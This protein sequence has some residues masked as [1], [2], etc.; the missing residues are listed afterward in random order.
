MQ[1]HIK[2]NYGA[3]IDIVAYL[4]TDRPIFGKKSHA[5]SNYLTLLLN[6]LLHA[7]LPFIWFTNIVG[8]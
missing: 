6:V 3:L 1:N 7:E 4:P 8:R 5:L 2:W